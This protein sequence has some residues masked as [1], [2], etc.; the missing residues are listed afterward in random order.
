MHCFRA[1]I[2]N[3]VAVHNESWAVAHSESE[4]AASERAD[5][6]RAASEGG[7]FPIEL[8]SPEG[9]YRLRVARETREGRPLFRLLRKA[10]TMIDE[11]DSPRDL[12]LYAEHVCAQLQART[13]ACAPAVLT[14]ML[15]DQA[16]RYP[17]SLD[18]RYAGRIPCHE[19][20]VR[21]RLL[22]LSLIHI[23]EPTRPY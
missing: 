13:T 21:R 16:K 12:A 5:A 3:Q 1:G 15:S 9:D 22:D 7:G 2:D 18:P 17:A 23:S 19:A 11:Y 6:E 10:Q 20:R 14:L 4:R 8:A